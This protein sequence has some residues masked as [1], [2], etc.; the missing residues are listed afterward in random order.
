MT[1]EP[2]GPLVERYDA[3]LFDLDGVVYLGPAPVPGAVEGLEQLRE[4]G[5]SIG[6]VTNNAARSPE[7]V[8]D[9]LRELG[10]TAQLSDV[11]TSAQACARLMATELPAGATVLV[12]GT[13]ALADEIRAVGLSVV[14]GIDPVPNAVVQGYDPTMSQPRLDQAGFAIQRGAR[15]FATNTDATRPTDQGLVPGA[16]A[17]IATVQAA[18]AVQPTV[19]GKPYA[20][21]MNETVRRLAAARPIFVGD[22]LDT[23]IEGA[24]GVGMDSLM[25]FTGA[26]GKADLAAAGPQSRPTHLGWDLRAL[27]DPVPEQTWHSTD[28]VQVGEQTARVLDGVVTLDRV[29]TDRAAQ[30]HA[31]QAVLQLLWAGH[32]GEA[33]LDQLTLIP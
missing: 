32:G 4:R 1:S 12:T 14:D 33:A 11:V 15:W 24:V 23:D 21:L 5:T 3:A 8:V 6:F 19:A 26:H 20:P 28:T 18:V 30:L 31:L 22:R 10:I 17:Q 27:L 9:H 13:S 16:G 29:P 25:V 2:H 7:H